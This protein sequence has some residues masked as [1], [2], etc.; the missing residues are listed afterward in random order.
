RKRHGQAVNSKG[1]RKR[2]KLLAS[3][4]GGTSEAEL[5]DLEE[6]GTLYFELAVEEIIDFTGKYSGFEVT[7]ITGDDSVVV[8]MK[9]MAAC[10]FSASV[11]CSS[12]PEWPLSPPFWGDENSQVRIHM[13]SSFQLCGTGNGATMQLSWLSSL[14]SEQ[15]FLSTRCGHLFCSWC[16]PVALE[17]SRA[18]PTCRTE[19][20]YDDY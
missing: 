5:V 16:L 4:A 13:L 11:L 2:S 7:N 20:T 6:N 9:L 12:W 1:A 10:F 8:S 14:R 15:L 17:T 19:L 3:S 18:C